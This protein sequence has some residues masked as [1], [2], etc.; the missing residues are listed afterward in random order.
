[1]ART[2]GRILSTILLDPDFQTL[3]EPAQRLY[4]ILLA[5][6]DLNTAGVLPITYRRWAR[7]CT[8][9]TVDHIVKVARE[10]DERRYVLLDEDTDEAFVRSLIRND[11]IAKQPQMLKNALRVA[12]Q[13]ASCR[14]RS[15]LAAELRRLGRDDA[16]ACADEI[17]PAGSP[18]P[19]SPQPPD[20]PHDP[21]ASSPIQAHGS[22]PTP[23]PQPVAR[24]ASLCADPGGEGV[25]EGVKSPNENSSSKTPDRA[26]RARTGEPDG[27]AEWY[28]AFPRHE[29]RAKAVSAYRSALRKR[30]ITVQFLL[31]GARRYRRLVEAEGRERSKILHPATWL[32]GERWADETPSDGPARL[33]DIWTIPDDQLTDADVEEILGPGRPPEPPDEFEFWDR[34]RRHAWNR[35]NYR[36]WLATRREQAIRSRAERLARVTRLD[37]HRRDIG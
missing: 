19:P 6:P 34:D 15:A 31:D 4:L 22:L 10:L 16:S 14:L 1:M 7:T 8:S 35:E 11:G 33:N 20:G 30:N 29:A 2:H 24:L 25:G 21:S 28:A 9:T 13:V 26:S 37:D 27:F 12:T 5:Q 36:N 3:S 23:S 18:R 17:D 32:N